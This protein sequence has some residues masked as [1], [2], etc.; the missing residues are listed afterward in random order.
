MIGIALYL[1]FIEAHFSAQV[2]TRL[3]KSIKT[4]RKNIVYATVI[5]PPTGPTPIHKS[6][7]TDYVA[8]TLPRQQ[9]TS[10]RTL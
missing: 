4:L 8:M 3:I 9:W 6:V 10:Q 2:P 5:T 1:L 7:C